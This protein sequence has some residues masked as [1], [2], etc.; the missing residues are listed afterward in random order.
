MNSGSCGGGI[1]GRI[2]ARAARGNS[3]PES[4]HMHRLHIVELLPHR[5]LLPVRHLPRSQD[6]NLSGDTRMVW[7]AVNASQTLI[8]GQIQH[9]SL[10]CRCAYRHSQPVCCYVG[11]SHCEVPEIF[12]LLGS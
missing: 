11:M 3:G 12:K 1:C 4:T 8:R 9:Q 2:Q 10:H 7:H 5:M 6:A